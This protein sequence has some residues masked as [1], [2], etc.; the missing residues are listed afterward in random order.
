MKMNI[1]TTTT[2][3]TLVTL[4][5]RNQTQ[6]RLKVPIAVLTAWLHLCGVHKTCIAKV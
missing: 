6:I 4:S 1:K 2:Q 3:E 5:N